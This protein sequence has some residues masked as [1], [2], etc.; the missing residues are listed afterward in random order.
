[1]KKFL[2]VVLAVFLLIGVLAPKVQAEGERFKVFAEVIAPENEKPEQINL[3]ITAEGLLGEKNFS[4]KKVDG[5][6]VTMKGQS[7]VQYQIKPEA[8]PGFSYDVRQVEEGVY[9]VILQKEGY[10]PNA[11]EATP[12][13][14][15]AP[16]ETAPPV[17]ELP[18]TGEQSMDS[19]MISAGLGLLVGLVLLSMKRH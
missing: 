6:Q 16:S 15:P 4:L 17:T 14:T 5:Y 13:T 9:K 2:T 10:D 11:T 3:T 8:I 18:T 1:M 19:V 7:G 12:E